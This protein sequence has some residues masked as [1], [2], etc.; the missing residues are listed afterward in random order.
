MLWRFEAVARRLFGVEP[1]SVA[2]Y[3]EGY[4]VGGVEQV[5]G[6]LARAA[7]SGGVSERLLGAL[8]DRLLDLEWRLTLALDA[9]AGRDLRAPRPAI[10]VLPDTRG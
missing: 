6:Y 7:V 5:Y 4:G 10:G 1:T 9:G 2:G 3:S 8:E